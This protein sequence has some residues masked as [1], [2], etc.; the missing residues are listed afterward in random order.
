ML[1][2]GQRCRAV[3]CPGD[4]AP[5]PALGS[6]HRSRPPRTRLVQV[7]S[8]LPFTKI[9]YFESPRPEESQRGEVSGPRSHSESATV[10]I[11]SRVSRTLRQGSLQDGEVTSSL[12][13][14][15]EKGPWGWRPREE[16]GTWDRVTGHG[17]RTDYS[18][19]A[20]RAARPAG[21]ACQGGSWRNNTHRLSSRPWVSGQGLEPVTRPL[22]GVGSDRK[23][24]Q[25]EDPALEEIKTVWVCLF[26]Q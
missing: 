7:T 2:R 13:A 20:G 4:T 8:P 22:A 16:E 5:E 9:I 26:F 24:G 15:V 19:G 11:L 6:P 23:G 18:E 3:I 21:V 25:M 14:D 12:F 1:E 10:G 17:A